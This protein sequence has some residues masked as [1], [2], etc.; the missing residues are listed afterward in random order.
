MELVLASTSP[1]RKELLALITQ[2]M[3]EKTFDCVSPDIDESQLEFEIATD[4]VKRLAL[5]KAKVGAVLFGDE[6]AI[7]LGSDTIVVVDDDILGKPTSY[8]DAF[9]MLTRLSGREHQVM[10]AVAVVSQDGSNVLMVETQVEF[11]DLTASDIESY[12][13]SGEP[14]DKAGSYGIQGIAGAFIKNI[15]GSYSAVV[16]LPM[17]ET[18]QLLLNAQSMNSK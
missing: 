11:C 3:P 6:K 9:D 10:T 2:L 4:Y 15:I 18:R 16:G 8:Q 5:Q 1:R 13:E 7:V 17:M 12:I 14:M